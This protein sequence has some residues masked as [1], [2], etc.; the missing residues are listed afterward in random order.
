MVAVVQIVPWPGVVVGP[1]TDGL[2]DCGWLVAGVESLTSHFI[3]LKQTIKKIEKKTERRRMVDLLLSLVGVGVGYW[4]RET[5]LF[6]LRLRPVVKRGC[7]GGGFYFFG[8]FTFTVSLLRNPT[9]G[10]VTTYY[11]STRYRYQQR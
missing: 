1:E 9:L 6:D 11:F 8:L 4:V 2:G 5:V 10:E 3:F 7:V